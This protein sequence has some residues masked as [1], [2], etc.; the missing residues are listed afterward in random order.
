MFQTLPIV[1]FLLI[2]ITIPGK[3]EDKSHFGKL[4]DSTNKEV[5]ARP[6]G[7]WERLYWSQVEPEVRGGER[8]Y[9][10]SN[11]HAQAME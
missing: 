10:R 5:P 7:M 11:I 9:R 1:S 2:T 3:V 8:K 6:K 4:E